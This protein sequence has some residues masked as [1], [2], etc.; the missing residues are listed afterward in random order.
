MKQ[1]GGRGA[2]FP[3]A[4][5]DRPVCAGRRGIMALYLRSQTPEGAH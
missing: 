3:A 2:M 4:A 1:F 5:C